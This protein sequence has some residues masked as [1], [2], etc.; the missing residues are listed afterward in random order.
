MKNCYAMYLQ[1]ILCNLNVYM[2]EETES[3]STSKSNSAIDTL[4]LEL[5]TNRS[6]YKRYL[7]KEQPEKFQKKQSH[8]TK[9]KK[10]APRIKSL[11]LDLL[12]DPDMPVTNDVNGAFNQFLDVCV[13]HFEMRDLEDRNRGYKAE[14]DDAEFEEEEMFGT[15]DESAASV[16]GLSPEHEPFVKSLWGNQVIRRKK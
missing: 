11:M 3:T 6:Q 13:R 10:Y 9:I 7:S 8:L 12:L 16:T 4:S 1:R 2:S 5:L 15:I 14:I